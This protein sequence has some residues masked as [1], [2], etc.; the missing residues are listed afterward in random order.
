MG[1]NSALFYNESNSDTNWHHIVHMQMRGCDNVIA[2]GRRFPADWRKISA[3][4]VSSETAGL[5]VYNTNCGYI[6]DVPSQCILLTSATDI[7]SYSEAGY[8]SARDDVFLKNVKRC[9]LEK[10]VMFVL[11]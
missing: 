2:Q 8:I 6:L 4:L 10:D 9:T 1:A 11:G 3:S 7:S 5:T